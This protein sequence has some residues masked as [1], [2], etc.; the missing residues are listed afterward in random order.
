MHT[1]E[2]MVCCQ[3]G[4]IFFFINLYPSNKKLIISGFKKGYEKKIN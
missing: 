3:P 4:D 1:L 2:A